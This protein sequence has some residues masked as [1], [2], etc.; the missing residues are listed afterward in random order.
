VFGLLDE[1]TL[2]P[3]EVWRNTNFGNPS[4]VGAG[5][6][7]ANPEGDGVPNLIKYA[8]GLNPSTPV[9]GS[10]LP[11]ASIL[12]AGGQDY[13]TL[14]VNRTA[15][16]TDVTYVVE[17]SGD[18]MMWSSGPSFTVTISNVSTQLIVRDNTP[19]ASATSRFIRL[20]V[21]DP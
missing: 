19:M 18:L 1:S 17:V 6:D 12:P 3:L 4:N 2:T 5:A 9:S 7:T 21:S 11:V 8:L 10:Q 13:L 16:A 15:Q 20:H 14:T